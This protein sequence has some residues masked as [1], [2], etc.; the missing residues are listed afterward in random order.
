M[1][2]IRPEQL[3]V[4]SQPHVKRFEDWMLAHLKKFFPKESESAGESGLRE[5]IQHGI[6]RAAVYGIVS[7]RDVCKYIELMIVFGRDFDQ[8]EKVPWAGQILRTRNSPG[9]KTSVLVETA[10]KKLLEK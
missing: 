7:E 4:L 9:L 3:A 5:T 1:L 6:K 8:D 10:H 2:T